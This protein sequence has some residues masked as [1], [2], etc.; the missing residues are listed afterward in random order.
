M[1]KKNK[2]KKF[3]KNLQP[4]VSE[5]KVLLAALGGIAAGISLASILGIEK[6]KHIVQTVE[7]SVKD[8][9]Q[10]IQDKL[11]DE[12]TDNISKEDKPHNRIKRFEKV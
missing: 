9:T 12:N 4:L 7:D 5:N 1:G 3:K 6:A 10:K 11:T 2:K 8:F